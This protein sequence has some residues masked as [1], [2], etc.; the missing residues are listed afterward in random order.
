MGKQSCILQFCRD[1]DSGS[2]PGTG[3]K[4]VI[5]IDDDG[6]IQES[7]VSS[8]VV[9]P[10][11]LKSLDQ[12][13][14]DQREVHVNQ[15]LE[16]DRLPPKVNRKEHLP[17]HKVSV[18]APDK[19]KKP[20]QARKRP[21]LPDHKILEFG[22]DKVAVDGF[23]YQKD[24]SIDVYLL[25]HFHSD[26]YGG[27]KKSW[28][29]GHIIVATKTTADLCVHRFNISPD[30]FFT[31]E[32]GQTARIPGTKV[33][34]TCLDANH[35]P[36]S[37]IFILEGAGKRYL[38]CG[39]FRVCSEMVHNLAAF[40]KFDRVYL[41]TTYL[42]P[43]YAFPRQQDVIEST[44]ELIAAK[45]NCNQSAQRRVTDFFSSG[46]PSEFLVVVGTYSIGKERLAIELARRFQ[47]KLFC[48]A[49]KAELLLQIGWKEL[50]DVLETDPKQAPKCKVHLVAMGGNMNKDALIQYLK[51]YRS[52][53]KAV[54][55]ITPTGWAYR[56]QE[57]GKG[58]LTPAQYLQKIVP[59]PSKGELD[60]SLLGQFDSRNKKE[61]AQSLFIS[62]SIRVPYSEHSSFR[63]LFYFV[64]LV[65][66]NEW[67][68]TVNLDRNEDNMRW[69]K[70][71]Q[72]YPSG[73][74]IDDI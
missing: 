63:E 37:G 36:G 60:K 29:N 59:V 20:R 73:L 14:I 67:I 32:Y 54:V 6:V 25:T 61:R 16:M 48:N 41:D 10:I 66:C 62:K 3:T 18:E 50:N 43:Q 52:R 13:R 69:I 34:V 45:S 44:C 12:W 28:N 2:A 74:Q 4:E 17:K 46:A 58:F 31:L 64:N 55:G 11:C 26:H 72:E 51:P 70:L 27:M 57:T 38:H 49:K 8:G 42:D 40:G 7:I 24:E 56:F 47:T 1:A 33:D 53:Y 71:F 22:E 68:P 15:C 35:C 23:C 30:M 5:E 21:S 9:C 19:K 65:D 39:D